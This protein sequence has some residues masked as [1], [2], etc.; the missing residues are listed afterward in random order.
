M[1][2]LSPPLLPPSPPDGA[3]LKL[4]HNG[5]DWVIAETPEQAARLATDHTGEKDAILQEAI[6]L[7]EEWPKP[8]LRMSEDD[9]ATFEEKTV[10]EWIAL[11]GPG[12]L[13]STEF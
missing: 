4:W 11:K 10:A 12:F 7:Y 5:F 2:S 13:C 9:G 3:E 1:D 6:D 8:T